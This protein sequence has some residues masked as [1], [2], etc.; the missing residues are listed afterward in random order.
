MELQF[1]GRH[2]AIK[3]ILLTRGSFVFTVSPLCFFP[4]LFL[5]PCFQHSNRTAIFSS[6]ALWVCGFK[7]HMCRENDSNGIGHAVS[8]SWSHAYSVPWPLHAVPAGRTSFTTYLCKPNPTFSSIL[9]QKFCSCKK[10][11]RT[12][13]H[14]FI[15]K[16][17]LGHCPHPRHCC[18]Q[19]GTHSRKYIPPLTFPFRTES[20]KQQAVGLQT[21]PWVWLLQLAL[22]GSRGL[23]CWEGYKPVIVTATAM[24]IRSHNIL[25]QT[26]V[27]THG[28][29][30][31]CI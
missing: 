3:A 9:C 11:Y 31:T 26:C 7:W 29:V 24:I 28:P 8:T 2:F 18:V 22:W 21:S 20:Y 17:I 4:Y 5:L 25:L 14:P 19:V 23:Q 1:Y 15:H 30:C 6:Q 27:Y 10:P 12:Q 13:L 16:I